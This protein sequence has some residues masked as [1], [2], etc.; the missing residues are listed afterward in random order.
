MLHAWGFII[1]PVAAELFSSLAMLA[2]AFVAHRPLQR[3]AEKRTGQFLRRDRSWAAIID[4]DGEVRSR[5]VFRVVEILV[6]LYHFP[7]LMA[8][9]A[10]RRDPPVWAWMVA[11]PVLYGA[12]WWLLFTRGH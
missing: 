8:A 5:H 7:V 4:E 1:W 10:V 6:I 12:L 11:T 9:N 2:I 3:A